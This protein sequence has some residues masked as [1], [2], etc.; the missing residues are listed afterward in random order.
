MLPKH[1]TSFIGRERELA[2]V[3]RLLAE[4]RLLTL[5]GSGG[6]GKTRLALRVADSWSPESEQVP[7]SS[8]SSWAAL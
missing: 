5:V 4:N 7:A 2:T 1:L 6:V 8:S 3:S